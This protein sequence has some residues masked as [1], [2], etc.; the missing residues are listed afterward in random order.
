MHECALIWRVLGGVQ[1]VILHSLS[2]PLL[3]NVSKEVFYPSQSKW[4]V[5]LHP[6]R[7]MYCF[8]LFYFVLTPYVRTLLFDRKA[9]LSQLF[10]LW[11][12]E[13]LNLELKAETVQEST[14]GVPCLTVTA[15]TG[16]AV[17]L[18]TGTVHVSGHSTLIQY[19]HSRYCSPLEHKH[20][21]C[22]GS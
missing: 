7:K 22:T 9:F 13:P 19:K 17:H 1:Y 10:E 20:S 16:T 12:L 11:R 3:W 8:Y 6:C 18:N 15:T 21:S 4:K 5:P 14:L 2:Q